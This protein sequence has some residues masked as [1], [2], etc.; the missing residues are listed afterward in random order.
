MREQ[1][2][3]HSIHASRAQHAPTAPPALIG[4]PFPQSIDGLRA[5]SPT[6]VI[7]LSD[8][9]VFD[10]E[11]GP[12]RRWLGGRE[13]RMLAY[14]GSVPG[15]AL[16]V[17]Q[18]DSIGL[19][20]TNRMDIETTVHWHGLRVENRFDGMPGHGGP[21]AVQPGATFEYR[22]RFPDAG[23]YWYHPH[24]REDYAQEH[25]L[26]GTIV[27]LPARAD[28]WPPAN[29]EVVLA[30]DDILLD[31]EGIAP[32]SRSTSRRTAMGRFGNVML[33]NGQ[34]EPEIE[35]IAGQVTRLYLV[36]TANVRT[37]N[38]AIPGA[39]MKLIGGDSGPFEREEPVEEV[40]V[41]PSERLVVDVLVDGPA[42]L[43]VEHRTPERT[44][45]LGRL[46]VRAGGP[47]TDAA[48]AF[49]ALRNNSWLTK[50]LASQRAAFDRSP[51]KTLA[52]IGS[53]P[54][55]KHHAA[56]HAAP[57]EWEDTMPGMNLH[58][59]P[60]NMHWQLVDEDTGLVNHAIDWSFDLGDQVLLR[61]RNDRPS[62]HPMQHP[63]HVHG[64]RLLVVRRNGAANDNLG[65]KD[66][67]LVRA[68]DVVDLLVDMSNPGT[69]MAHCHIA[70]HLEANM[71][72][73][74]R[75]SEPTGRPNAP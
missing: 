38:V 53:M 51:D 42:T 15:P 47:P 57:I 33:L 54:G 39:R 32:I 27:V 16:I 12:V 1:H 49:A 11:A 59:T 29:R 70:E 35:V 37:F 3:H 30:V 21:P 52:L 66:T 64:Q 61:V 9:D 10:L 14:N 40:L 62:D 63:L 19:R 26:Y 74:F 67:V 65:W 50:E 13:L 55:M 58:S 18:G 31:D 20:F 17:R 43:A 46:A 24:V 36:N 5:A 6:P 72:L 45:R 23:I 4:D 8:G 60:A 34:V 25:G 44:Y 7:R 41:S 73:M 69:W 68:G 56:H 71:M 48:V 22:L 2:D 75:V 28:F